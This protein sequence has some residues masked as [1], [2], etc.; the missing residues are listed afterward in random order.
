MMSHTMAT[1]RAS[2]M[3]VGHVQKRVGKYLCDL[4]KDKT[5][6]DEHGKRPVFNCCLTDAN[7]NKLPNYYSNAIRAN[8][9]NVESIK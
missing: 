6:K 4:K 8:V 1:I 9:C 5:L 7:I 2:I 3:C